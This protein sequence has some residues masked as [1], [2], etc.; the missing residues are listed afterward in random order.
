MANKARESMKAAL[1]SA[2]LSKSQKAAWKKRKAKEI[3]K[4][5]T[6]KNETIDPVSHGIEYGD[7]AGGTATVKAKAY[8]EVPVDELP[9][10]SASVAPVPKDV[11]EAERRVLT[12]WINRAGTPEERAKRKVAMLGIMYNGSADSLASSIDRMIPPPP[13]SDPINPAHYQRHPSGIECIVITEHFNFNRGNAIK[14]IWRADEKGS[15]L[16]NLRKA[17]WYLNR[18]I[19]KLEKEA[20]R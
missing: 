18:E 15:S 16:E 19:E 5:Y 6:V 1:K 4:S 3:A 8:E 10:F 2:R 11:P 17:Q 7:A 20:T 9:D 13:H 12:D 14:Y